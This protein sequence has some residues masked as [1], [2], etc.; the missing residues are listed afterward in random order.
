V[1]ENSGKLDIASFGR[2]LADIPSLLGGLYQDYFQHHFPEGPDSEAW[3]Q[4]SKLVAMIAVASEPLPG[5]LAARVSARTYCHCV[6]ACNDV[7][8]YVNA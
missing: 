7:N 4:A 1:E 3:Q 6:S 8:A 2:D 5:V